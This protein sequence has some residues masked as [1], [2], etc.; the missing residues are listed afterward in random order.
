MVTICRGLKKT[1]TLEIISFQG[2]IVILKQKANI[3]GY[4]YLISGD[5]LVPFLCL[6]LKTLV[7][8]R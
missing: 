7:N 3:F 4:L 8:E 5:M 1:T 6:S 2:L